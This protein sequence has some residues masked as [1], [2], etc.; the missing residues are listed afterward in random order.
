MAPYAKPYPFAS[1]VL[2][3]IFNF[4]SIDN[5]D[6]S[7]S[8]TSPEAML[9]DKHEDTLR[10]LHNHSGDS[11]LGSHK[12]IPDAARKV[13]PSKGA[14][15]ERF[16]EKWPLMPSHMFFLPPLLAQGNSLAKCCLPTSKLQVAQN[17][18]KNGHSS[19]NEQIRERV[20]KLNPHVKIPKH[21]EI[22]GIFRNNESLLSCHLDS[23]SAIWASGPNGL[24]TLPKLKFPDT[25][26]NGERY[27]I[28][29]FHLRPSEGGFESKKR[30][31]MDNEREMPLSP[32]GFRLLG[33][34]DLPEAKRKK[35][36]C[37]TDHLKNE[38]HGERKRQ[39]S[40]EDKRSG[41]EKDSKRVDN[42]DNVEQSV[43]SS[44]V[45]SEG[46]TDR[47]ESELNPR[48]IYDQ[49]YPPDWR[50]ALPYFN[51]TRLVDRIFNHHDPHLSRR[52]RTS[53]SSSVWVPDV[54]KSA[55]KEQFNKDGNGSNV[56]EAWRSEMNRLFCD[57]R[58]KKTIFSPNEADRETKESKL[59]PEKLKAWLGEGSLSPKPIKGDS[60]DKK[61]VDSLPNG[62][63]HIQDFQRKLRKQ[64]PNFEDKSRSSPDHRI[65]KKVDSDNLM[66]EQFGTQGVGVSGRFSPVEIRGYNV[67]PVSVG[68]PER[69]SPNIEAIDSKKWKDSESLRL[70]HDTKIDAVEKPNG[71]VFTDH[72]TLWLLNK[73]TRTPQVRVHP[74]RPVVSSSP[75][76]W[77]A[78]SGGFG[79]GTQLGLVA[80]NTHE[81]ARKESSNATHSHRCEICNSSFPLR[82]LLNRH[83][84]THSFYKRYTCSYCDKGFNDTF[85][86]KRHVRTHTG[87]KPFKCEQCDKSFTQR[88]SLEAHQTRVH[89]MVHKFGFRER[90]SKMFVC[91]E[92]GAT[93]RDNQ[94]EFMS[95]MASAHADRE[96]AT[97]VKKSP[98]LCSQ[99][100]T[101]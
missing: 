61:S 62:K 95:H 51:S 94:S 39:E 36:S 66:K 42:V 25:R 28:N 74:K 99:V 101:F 24:H 91:E 85:D 1:L 30:T 38:E 60:S 11:T 2:I 44:T 69:I 41:Q 87:I 4:S 48:N 76:F 33:T 49:R 78:T 12:E 68:S 15:P 50:I 67:S 9:N 86:L 45:Q 23:T 81:N 72:S 16:T 20:L 90:R 93:F 75:P 58:E 100:I 47:M 18:V 92:C 77:M 31:R 53:A 57:T 14:A 10:T 88:C 29:P 54:L 98:S 52:E 56:I 35:H 84:K 26:I 46:I 17:S 21:A 59:S 22:Q 63:D 37:S 83:L 73:D 97:W 6:T 65:I 34:L 80:S 89:G 71:K 79:V 43:H 13:L 70:H 27:G 5:G 19:P 32:Q 64:E 8:L 55:A 40:D 82:R 3:E 7:R 96:K